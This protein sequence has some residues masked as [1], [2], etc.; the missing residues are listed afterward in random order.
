M[1]TTAKKENG[2]YI[3]NG[4]KWFTSSFDGANFAIVMVVTDPDGEDVHKKA[5]QIIVPLKTEG[6]EFVRNISIMGHPG[7]G[8]ES[9]AEIKFNN[10]KVP[11]TN[12]LGSEGEGFAIAHDISVYSF[13]ALAKASQDIMKDR[14]ASLLTLS[15]LG[16]QR[17]LP[18]Y[19]VMGIAKA[20]LESSTRY[21]ANS[22][23][24]SKIRV[25]AISLGIIM[26]SSLRLNLH[27]NP[28][29]Q[30]AIIDATPLGYI[31]EPEEVA[32]LTLF[33]SSESARFLT[34]QVITIDGGRSIL[35]KLER[36]A[37]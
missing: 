36:A 6:V 28:E 21:L 33:L 26:S 24:K 17:T 1:G 14:N 13:T 5:S 31:A 37:Y 12:V 2:C 25:N 18:N 19:N 16:S 22:L 20:S 34:G 11:I 10:V 8:W 35:N 30:D 29:L 27:S 4:H 9:H 15:Y 7:A 3:I 23:G 32:D